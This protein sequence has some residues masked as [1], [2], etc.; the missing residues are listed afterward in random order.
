MR[1]LYFLL[2]SSS[3]SF[4]VLFTKI[5][6]LGIW[7]GILAPRSVFGIF[8]DKMMIFHFY[9]WAVFDDFFIFGQILMIFLIFGSILMIFFISGA[10]KLISWKNEIA[11]SEQLPDEATFCSNT[12]WNFY[13]PTSYQQKCVM[14]NMCA[15]ALLPDPLKV[16]WA[17]FSTRFQKPPYVC[18]C[19]TPDSES[20]VT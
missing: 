14:W 16:L 10:R 2:S 19:G 1:R 6:N 8:W 13:Y 11:P 15:S 5:M 3:S 4:L 9:F 18:A 7:V 17:N 12:I 20:H